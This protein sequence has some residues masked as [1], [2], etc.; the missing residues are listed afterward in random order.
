MPP[1]VH[2][3]PPL[4]STGASMGIEGQIATRLQEG[5]TPKQ[6]I[7]E[8]FRKSTVYKV[9]E[10]LRAHQAPAPPPP[11]LVSLATD[12]D[13]YLPGE[14]AH[15]TVTLANRTTADLYVFQ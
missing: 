7:A 10:T 13:R 5:A 3:H 9:A 14:T 15:A 12:R 11:L 1:R 4:W 2:N 8:G 6:L